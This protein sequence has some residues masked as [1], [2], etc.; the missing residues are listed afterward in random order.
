LAAALTPKK[1][2]KP[3]LKT[4]AAMAAMRA[5]E[6]HWRRGKHPFIGRDLRHPWEF[7]QLLR[8]L[9]AGGRGC[10]FHHEGPFLKRFRIVLAGE[11]EGNPS[12]F[13]PGPDRPPEFGDL[14]FRKERTQREE[15]EAVG[16]GFLCGRIEGKGPKS[17]GAGKDEAYAQNPNENRK[18]LAEI[19]PQ[20]IRAQKRKALILP[21]P[22]GK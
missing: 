10:Q 4:N 7:S 3:R 14:H 22:E 8:H 5:R 9:L 2:Q 15:E 13:R 20:K 1:R 11:T 16:L 19:G 18:S 12:D 17:G 6:G 21:L